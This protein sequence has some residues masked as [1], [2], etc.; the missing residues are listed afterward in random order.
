MDYYDFVYPFDASTALQS[1]LVPYCAFW[2]DA[3]AAPA[4]PPPPPAV[5]TLIL[6]GEQDLRTPAAGAERVQASIPGAQLLV[7]P[8]TGHSVLGSDFSGC[9]EAAVAAFFSGRAVQ[10]CPSALNLFAPTPISPTQLTSLRPPRGL[11]GKP[12]RTLT[13]V[14][15]AIRDLARQVIAATLQA[16]AELPS[17]SSFGGLRG[18]YARLSSS[19]VV[20]HGFSFVTGVKVS[21]AFRVSGGRLEPAKLR[22]FGSSAA[23]GYVRFGTRKRVSGVLGGRRFDLSLARLQASRAALARRWPERPPAHPLAP[24]LDRP[25]AHLPPLP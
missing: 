16:E 19:A 9:A 22:V 20:L 14:V 1:S 4:A 12:G 24:L 7:V 15:D 8:Y 25:P 6:S 2:P 17:G 21:G 23:A 3:S 5:P 11:G 13:A 18:G 10:P